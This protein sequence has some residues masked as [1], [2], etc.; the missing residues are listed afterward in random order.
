MKISG[1]RVSD[2]TVHKRN[3]SETEKGKN[4]INR[5]LLCLYYAS[6]RDMYILEQDRYIYI[7]V[8]EGYG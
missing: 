7:Q 1:C 4:E 5:V 2:N 6:K 3:K 8:V